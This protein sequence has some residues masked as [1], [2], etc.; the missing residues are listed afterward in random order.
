MTVKGSRIKVELNGTV[1]LD[2]DLDASLP[3]IS[4]A[5]TAIPAAATA[6]AISRPSPRAAPVTIAT[7]CM[8]V[9]AR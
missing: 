4:L 9:T 6:C 1:I 7:P 2:T 5:A 3:S 8:A